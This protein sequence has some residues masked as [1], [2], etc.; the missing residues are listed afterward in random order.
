MEQMS[1]LTKKVL[2]F[3][4]PDSSKWAYWTSKQLLN[5]VSES[6]CMESFKERI[7]RAV[8]NREKVIVAGDYDCDGI[9]ATT[10]MV[11]GLRKLG[12]ECGFYIPDR[13]KEGYGLSEATVML[14]HKKGYSLTLTVD[15]GIKSKPALALSKELGMD[16]IVT[17]HHTMDEE[18]NCDIVVHPDL[19]EPCFE[20][21]CGAGIAYECMRKLGVEDDYLLQLAGLASISDMMVVKGQT[22]AL[23]QNALRSINETHEKHIFS[24]AT[25]RDLNETSIGFQ[26]VP[27]LNAIGRLSNLANVNNV[28][29]YFLAHDD[30][31]IYTLGS[32]ITQMNTIRKQMSDQ[33]QKTALL[34]CK[35]NEDIYII[36]DTSFHEGIIGLVAGALCSR[37]NKPCIVL[38]KN[39]QGYKA[40]MRSPEGFNC[41]EFLGPYKHFVVFGGHENAAGF[42]LNL[43]EFDLFEDFVH[44]RIKEYT[45]SVK[46]KETLIITDDELS[47]ETIQSLDVLRPF[48]PGFVFPS[49]EIIHPQIKSLYDFQNHKHRKYT[50]ESGLQCMRFNQSEVEYKKS[51]N[52]IHSFIGTAQINQYQG[53]KQVN[54][55]IDE[56]VYE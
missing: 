14:A 46:K 50:L 48:G 23:I 43:N 5:P 51:V 37:F 17:D 36:E 33:M 22:R 2:E 34:K 24:L 41:M 15:N 31:T 49:F 4:E 7:L 28:V 11:S 9:S 29:R 42:S 52:A 40:S 38:A 54:F 44:A 1:E 56:I 21:L 53:R 32:Q 30:E 12:L 55:V 25:D 16:V 39:E 13:I 35:S 10:I 26:V 47:L 27:K 8:S 18:V 6:K 20:T 19:M 3:L 45:Y